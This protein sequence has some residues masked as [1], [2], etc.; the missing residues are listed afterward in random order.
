ML[1]LADPSR[2]PGPK[3]TLDAFFRRTGSQWVTAVASTVAG[4]AGAAVAGKELRRAAFQA[5][6]AR[7]E[8]LW[9]VMEEMNE[10]EVQQEA[11]E[12]MARAASSKRGA[13]AAAAASSGKKGAGAAAAEGKGG[14]HGGGGGGKA[15]KK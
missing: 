13:G 10:L 14:K 1:D 15:G 7:Y 9:P 4:E 11:M 3:E 2:T 12:A 8:E 6:R 5:A